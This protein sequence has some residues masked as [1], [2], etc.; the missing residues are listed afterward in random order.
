MK[1]H[2]SKILYSK[3]FLGIV[4][5]IL[6]VMGV[7]EYGKWQERKQIDAEIAALVAEEQQL[8]QQ[9]KQLE[10]SISFLGS[11]E[12]K[13]KLARLQLN[14]KKDGEIVVNFLPTAK[15]VEV[16]NQQPKKGSNIVKWWE[17]IFV[18]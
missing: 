3:V 18:N 9:N 4:T 17:Y 13:E 11:E 14:L 10:E 15:P 12:Y 1:S 2:P 5:I 7:V 8:Q 6:A 16:T